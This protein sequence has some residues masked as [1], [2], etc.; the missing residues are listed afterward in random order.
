MS[1][2]TLW[3]PHLSSRE[4][5]VVE[6]F[7]SYGEIAYIR[8]GTADFVARLLAGGGISGGRRRWSMQRYRAVY[9]TSFPERPVAAG[10]GDG[11]GGGVVRMGH[12]LRALRREY[13]KMGKLTGSEEFR[14][15]GTDV[16][17]R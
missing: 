2:Y 15:L 13:R 6:M 14:E 5:P 3:N 7:V 8:H 4:P 10:G 17:L 1:N 16:D 12:V 11:G 9:F